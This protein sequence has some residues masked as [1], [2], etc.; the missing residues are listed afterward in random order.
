M[1]SRALHI[2]L[3]FAVTGC[4]AISFAQMPTGSVKTSNPQDTAI[5]FESPR[6]LL[7]QNLAGGTI[8]N[9]AGFTGSIN[10]Y[11]F[12]FGLYFRR[13]LTAD[14]SAAITFD[15]GGGK[16]PKEFGLDDEVKINRIYVMP[17]MASLQ[18]RLF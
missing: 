3:V 13:N 2:A 8:D 4:A 10:D 18:Y 12:G 15:I 11:G 16:G 14:L 1:K 9:S 17:L 6:P 5:I 7:E